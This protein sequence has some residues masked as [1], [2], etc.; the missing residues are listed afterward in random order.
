MFVREELLQALREDRIPEKSFT[1]KRDSF[2]DWVAYQSRPEASGAKS[3]YGARVRIDPLHDYPVAFCH[4]L[5]DGNWD[6][7]N[8]VV[9]PLIK[10]DLV[11]EVANGMYRVT[12]KGWEHLESRPLVSGVQGFVAMAFRPE[13]DSLYLAIAEAITSAGFRPR[14]IDKHEYI[15]GVLDEIVAQIRD[16]RFLVADLTFNRGGV[17]YEAG[18]GR[19][20]GIPV[21]PTCRADQLQDDSKHRIHFDMQ[22]LNV[23][24]WKKGK[25]LELTRRLTDRIVA[26]LG[27]GP[28]AGPDHLTYS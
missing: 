2:L 24:G 10:R 4:P 7:W 5:D 15:G 8:F 25:L 19:A 22:H 11:N 20:L 6:E 1:Q 3:P 21:I 9:Q 28:L 12:E 27:R 26:V 18:F 13:L 23:I 14:R 16:S 17:Y